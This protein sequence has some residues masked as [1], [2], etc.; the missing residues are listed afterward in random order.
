MSGGL[1][2]RGQRLTILRSAEGSS[3]LPNGDHS[4][5]SASAPQPDHRLLLLRLSAGALE[6]LASGD[7]AVV[8]GGGNNTASRVGSSVVGLCQSNRNP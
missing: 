3:I 8:S 5:V 6:I 2:N 7:Y 4:V 1:N